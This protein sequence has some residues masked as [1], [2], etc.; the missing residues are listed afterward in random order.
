MGGVKN[1]NHVFG[2]IKLNNSVIMKEKQR[3]RKKSE[4]WMA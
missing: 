4:M 2:L 3:L 1:N